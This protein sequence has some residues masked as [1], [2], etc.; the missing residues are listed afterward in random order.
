MGALPMLCN[1]SRLLPR[2]RTP[3][4]RRTRCCRRPQHGSGLRRCCGGGAAHGSLPR[5]RTR[6]LLRPPLA[7]PDPL[8]HRP[9][10][11]PPPV[12]TG[13]RAALLGP[14]SAAG[15]CRPAN[16]NPP[17][18]Q[19]RRRRRKKERQGVKGKPFHRSRHTYKCSLLRTGT[20]LSSARRRRPQGRPSRILMRR[21]TQREVNSSR[22]LRIGTACG[23]DCDSLRASL[24]QARR[25]GL[26]VDAIRKSE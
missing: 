15:G 21:V 25:A 20:R 5:A 19:L 16:P 14:P 26:Q 13:L 24:P 9:H 11:R 23:A 22:G 18:R 7:R 12:R 3:G 6:P 8:L 10:H 1:R 4:A 2:N 17:V